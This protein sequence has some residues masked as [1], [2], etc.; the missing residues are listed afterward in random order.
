MNLISRKGFV[1]PIVIFFIILSFITSIGLY[2][3]CYYI[4]KEIAIDE[5]NY[6]RGYYAALAGARYAYILLRDPTSVTGFHFDTTWSAGESRTLY[7]H[8]DQ[9]H[10]AFKN[11]IGLRDN[12][13]L[14]I[15][16]T[17]RSDGQYDVASTFSS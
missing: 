7:I 16:A 10:G 5:P 4:S 3:A 17:E 9:N 1:L 12:D 11:N 2:A 6:I 13:A 8:S 15:T 14:I